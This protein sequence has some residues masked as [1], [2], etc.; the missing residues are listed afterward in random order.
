MI[1]GADGGSM[2]SDQPDALIRL[3]VFEQVIGLREVHD[4][5]TEK[6]F[7]PG[8]TFYS[9]RVPPLISAG[10][11]Q[12]TNEIRATGKVP[13]MP[14]PCKV[15]ISEHLRNCPSGPRVLAFYP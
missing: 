14:L 3:A 2:S 15:K 8:F 10:H 4:Y 12:A 13:R 11:L 5:Q 6:E 9:E 7:K 1:L